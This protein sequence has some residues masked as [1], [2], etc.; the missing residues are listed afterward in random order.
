M[1]AVLSLARPF[2]SVSAPAAFALASR[3][4]R[5]GAARTQSSV[6]GAGGG[7][8]TVWLF[9][10]LKQPGF[11]DRTVLVT[12]K[13]KWTNGYVVQLPSAALRCEQG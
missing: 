13:C 12:T 3:L 9:P 10:W 1:R 5:A 7:D 4:G 11:A 6:A 2:S 8:A